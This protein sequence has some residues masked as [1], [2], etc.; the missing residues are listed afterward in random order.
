[1]RVGG[2]GVASLCECCNYQ[3][4]LV[5]SCT[6]VVCHLHPKVALRVVQD[7]GVEIEAPFGVDY[8]DLPLDQITS[9][10]FTSLMEYL[11]ELECE[12]VEE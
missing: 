1:M 4:E 12:S 3:G 6:A 10:L 7:I 9:D 11:D 8:N 2:V 5:S